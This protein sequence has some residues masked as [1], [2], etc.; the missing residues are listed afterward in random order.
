MI[1]KSEDIFI[2][3]NQLNI[4]IKEKE[5][6]FKKEQIKI[7]K[8]NQENTYLEQTKKKK[9]N[10][11]LMGKE[12]SE[13]VKEEESEEK[14]EI[15]ADEFSVLNLGKKVEELLP[16]LTSNHSLSKKIHNTSNSKNK[17][18]SIKREE[19]SLNKKI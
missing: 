9:R 3:N 8:L 18:L 15:K 14:D 13:E 10:N 4:L 2:E 5:S 16:S 11:N 7:K 1:I 6:S 17:Y 12:E 19:K